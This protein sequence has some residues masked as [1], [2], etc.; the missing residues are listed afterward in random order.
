MT[1]IAPFHDLMAAMLVTTTTIASGSQGAVPPRFRSR[2][3]RCSQLLPVASCCHGSRE[4][5]HPEDEAGQE[6]QAEQV[7]TTAVS[8]FLSISPIL[9]SGMIMKNIAF[10]MGLDCLIL[11]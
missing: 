5:F 8:P 1:E 9:M 10:I 7:E 3:K 2:E 11:E 6:D 4:D